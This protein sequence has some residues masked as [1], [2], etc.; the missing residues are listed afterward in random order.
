MLLKLVNVV[1]VFVQ[2]K[3]ELNRN[4]ERDRGGN[5]SENKKSSNSAR[6]NGDERRTP[7]IKTPSASETNTPRSTKSTPRTSRSLRADVDGHSLGYDPDVA[8]GEKFLQAVSG[9]YCGLC[10]K[11]FRSQE[12][13]ATHCKSEK[14]FEKY[15][16]CSH[17]STCLVCSKFYIFLITIL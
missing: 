4:K 16:V 2:A 7:R 8:V 9:F 5:G 10:H 15:Q 11:F 12:L 14:H 6:P 1:N 17:S 3:D 13:G